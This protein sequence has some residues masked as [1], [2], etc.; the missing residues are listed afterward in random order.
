MHVPAGAV[1]SGA[2]CTV[3]HTG[4][5]SQESPSRTYFFWP[6]L[7]VMGIACVLIT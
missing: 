6:V 1:T 7:R 3:G 5:P 2:K 4:G